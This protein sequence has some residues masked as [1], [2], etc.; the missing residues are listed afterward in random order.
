[1]STPS[2]PTAPPAPAA[3]PAPAPAR[4]LRRWW[5]RSGAL[6]VGLVAGAAVVAGIVEHLAWVETVAAYDAD[7]ARVT[8]EAETARARA[9]A[10]YAASLRSLDEAIDDGRSVYDASEDQVADPAVREPLVAALADAEELRATEVTYPVTTTRTVE[11][12]T[13]P[14]PLRR[15]TLP[16]VSVE[17]MGG[18][19]PAPGGLDAEAAGVA[20]VT[21]TVAAAR[22]QWALV[23]LRAATVEG[24]DAR[25]DLRGQV[26]ARA[27]GTLE[28]AVADAEAILDGGADAVDPDVAVPLR[29]TLFDTTHALWSA[30]LAEIHDERRAAARAAGVDCRVDRCVALTFDDGPVEDTRRLLRILAAKDAPA[31]FFL[32]GDNAAKRPDI[33]RAVADGGHLLANHSWA[34]PQLTTL[35]DADVRDELRRTQDAIAEAT[36][37]TPFLLRPPYGDVDGRVR[38]LATRTGLDVVLWSVDTED[39][40][41]RDA[42]ETRRRV[43]AQVAP[44]SN[45]LMHDIHPSTVDAVPKII[46][47]LRAEGYVLVTADLL[48]DR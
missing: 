11:S 36:G 47:D 21:D 26:G 30:R 42:E 33:V 40:S 10:A 19:E 18:S 15:E 22:R 39:W 24:R 13:R 38:S 2:G 4:R 41:A 44:G 1:M 43:R 29:D 46:D 9:E 3:A 27:L 12:V 20:E 23:E 31:T 35:D 34:H 25:A 32:V 45:V 48:T 37:F 5:W 7:I 8:D 17:V 16:E 28:E 14:N 6:A